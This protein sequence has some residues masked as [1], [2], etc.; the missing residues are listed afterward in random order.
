MHVLLDTRCCLASVTLVHCAANAPEHIHNTYCCYSPYQVESYSSSGD[1]VKLLVG[2]KVDR[3]LDREVLRDDGQQASRATA[4]CLH[5]INI[6][7]S[8]W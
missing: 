4:C 6:A 3:E 8:E 7:Q 1:V 2:N 5:A